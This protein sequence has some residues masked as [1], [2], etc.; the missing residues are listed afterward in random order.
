MAA[1]VL[2]GLA[3]AAGDDNE[4]CVMVP[5]AEL[6]AGTRVVV[7]PLGRGT[8]LRRE[9]NSAEGGTSHFAGLHHRLEGYGCTHH[10]TSGHCLRTVIRYAHG[11]ACRDSLAAATGQ[12]KKRLLGTDL[13]IHWVRFDDG[14]GG[15]D[16]LALTASKAAAG[17]V[18]VESPSVAVIALG[19]G[20]RFSVLLRPGLTVRPARH[21]PCTAR[22]TPYRPC[23]CCK[24]AAATALVA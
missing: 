16:T 15:G 4:R 7:K 6:P 23:R 8:Y 10:S 14:G 13:C 21:A 17:W 24:D 20:A 9:A 1:T 18:L 3:A 11:T 22:N 2:M 12:V 5:L 19:L